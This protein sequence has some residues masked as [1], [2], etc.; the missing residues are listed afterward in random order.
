MLSAKDAYQATDKMV[1]KN[2]EH[3][4]HGPRISMRIYVDNV[5]I[6]FRRIFILPAIMGVVLALKQIYRR[7]SKLVRRWLLNLAVFREYMAHY[8]KRDRPCFHSEFPLLIPFPTVFFTSTVGFTLHSRFHSL[9]IMNSF[10]I[11]P[12]PSS[13]TLQ[14]LH[15]TPVD[16][17]CRSF[18]ARQHF[19]ASCPRPSRSVRHEA[20]RDLPA[21]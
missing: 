2:G 4:I 6:S 17:R 5:R 10:L 12:L 18:P 1:K 19:H 7:W 15:R 16:A 3:R 20:A 13:P 21:C 14:T 11:C 8:I 9:L